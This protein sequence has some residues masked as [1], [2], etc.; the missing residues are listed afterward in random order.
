MQ[1]QAQA[2][3]AAL[4][5]TI[6]LKFYQKLLF[7]QSSPE[8]GQGAV[9]AND[10]MAGDKYADAIGADS[11]CHGPH[12]FFI[13]NTLSNFQVVSRF[14]VWD[15]EQCPPYPEL[16]NCADRVQ[17]NVELFAIAC[18]IFVKLSLCLFDN[19]GR[20]YPEICIY[21][22]PDSKF[23]SLGTRQSIP[24]AQA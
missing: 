19:R 2:G 4:V 14:S 24:V 6:P 18:K 17:R 9:A 20:R 11:L 22:S 21:V 10:A 7:I 1:I 23:V 12:A 16:K 3:R 15:I 5:K 13:A 8:A